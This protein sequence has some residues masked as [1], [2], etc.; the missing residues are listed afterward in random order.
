MGRK[1]SNSLR[2]SLGLIAVL[3]LLAAPASAFALKRVTV[4]AE[5]DSSLTQSD[6]T[7]YAN[8]QFQDYKSDGLKGVILMG[9]TSQYLVLEGPASNVD[10]E[11]SDLTNNWRIQSVTTTSSTFYP[12]W[13]FSSLESHT[14][15]DAYTTSPDDS[16]SNNL[17]KSLRAQFTSGVDTQQFADEYAEGIQQAELGGVMVL[18]NDGGE[19]IEIELEGDP[20]YVKYWIKMLKEDDDLTDATVVD[21][22]SNVSTTAYDKFW[23]HL[24]SDTQNQHSYN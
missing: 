13:T 20:T 16:F 3:L 15:T 8:T 5:L 9:T 21:T 17:R 19:W 12:I 6:R 2:T 7:D 14:E 10:T 23:L 18:G 22:E 11:I 24:P 1:L 4:R